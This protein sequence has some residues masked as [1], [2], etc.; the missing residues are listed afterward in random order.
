MT[1]TEIGKNHLQAAKRTLDEQP[2]SSASRAY[3]A[4]HVVLAEA[5]V[6]AGC[7]LQPGRQTPAHNAQAQLIGRHLT[8]QP[9]V[10]ELKAAIRKLYTRR[11]DADYKRTASV[12]RA[13]ALE[14]VRAASTIFQLL[15]VLE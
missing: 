13:S 2:R 8:P 7:I 9:K 10:R 6:Q 3:Y 5:L 4:A 1:W 11:I 12:D 15:G 14:S